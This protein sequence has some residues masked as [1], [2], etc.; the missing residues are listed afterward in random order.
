MKSSLHSLILFLSFLLNHLSPPPP[1]LDPFIDNNAT[2]TN[3]SSTNSLNFWQVIQIQSQ[4]HIATDGQSISKSWCRALS[5]AHDQ[6]FITLWQLRSYFCGAPSLTREPQMGL[7]T[8]TH[9]NYLLCPFIYPRHWQR[10][11][12]PLYCLEGLF[13]DPLRRNGR[14]VVIAYQRHFYIPDQ[15][16]LRKKKT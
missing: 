4:S 5:G 15:N 11:K 3:S 16:L 2:E 6:I 9:S 7:D 13:T 1:K 14:P 8:K 12:Q 10:R